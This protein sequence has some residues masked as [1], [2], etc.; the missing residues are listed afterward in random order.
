MLYPP[1]I[2]SNKT[3]PNIFAPLTAKQIL[4]YYD[5]NFVQIH[6]KTLYIVMYTMFS[7]KVQFHKGNEIFMK[8]TSYC[9]DKT[10]QAIFKCSKVHGLN[11]MAQA[12]FA[13]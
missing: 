1:R 11:C 2:C 7:E 12:H 5:H 13:C 8:E 9:Y 6:L 3:D 10:I 4:L